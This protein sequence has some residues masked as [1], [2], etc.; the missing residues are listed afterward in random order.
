MIKKFGITIGGLQQKIVNLVLIFALL[1]IGLFVTVSIYMAKD[2]TKI[3]EKSGAEQKDSITKVSQ[4]TM[5]GTLNVSMTQS[6]EMQASIADNLFTAAQG[7]VL[8]LQEYAE[9][10]FTHRDEYTDK[11]VPEPLLENDGIPSVQLQHEAAVDPADDP[12]LG[13]LANMNELLL[14][15][16][17]NSGVVNSTLAATTHGDIIFVDDR[18]GANFNDDGTLQTF[19][20]RERPWY[21]GAI[22]KGGLY[23]TGIELDAFTNIP[24]LV[25]S[26]P[27]YANGELVAVVG[28]DVFLYNISEYVN[29]STK[30]GGFVCIVNQNGEIIFSPKKDG[31]FKAVTSD[32]AADLRKGENAEL[33]AFVTKALTDTTGLETVTV[34]GVEYYLCGAP[35]KTVGWTVI[36]GVA[37]ELSDQPTN[38]MLAA[39]DGI[40]NEA[41]GEY[42]KASSHSQNVILLW[43]AILLTLAFIGALT[44]AGRIVKPIETMTRRIDELSEGDLQFKMEDAYRTK[45]EI[46]L[47]A[48]AFA[49]LSAK[50]VQYIGQI[51][52]ITAEKERIGAEL[53]LATRIQ[54]NMLPN[55]FPAFPQRSDFDI[56][57]S[58]TPAKEVGGDFYDFML[59]DDDHLAVVIADVSGKGVPAAL[60]MMMA[61]ILIDNTTRMEG[62]EASPGEVLTR[63][64]N[65]ICANNEEEM[66][67][68]VWLGI[69]DLKTGKVKATNAGHEYPIIKKADGKFELLKDKHGMVV[70]AMEGLRYKDY[71]FKLEEGGTLFLYTD[72]V[73]EATNA[74]NKLFGTERTIEALNE[75]P[76]ESPEKLLKK[77]KENVDIFVG[78][79][80]QFDDLTMI[81]VKINRQHENEDKNDKDVKS[82]KQ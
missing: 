63:V 48:E 20:V 79:A 15:M 51:T 7:N 60:F 16:Y 25:C 62:P 35:M 71:E 14:S 33:G 1:I 18:A 29:D 54:A 23:Y 13:L 42:N 56:Y 30:Y 67:V 49:E 22:E 47:L 64:N 81:S 19:E 8:T 57:A 76:E 12:D 74:E 44:V 37:K 24:G 46:E 65:T 36:S 27:V 38:A 52:T 21:T 66:F 43:T 28:A 4:E 2:L 6:A 5:Q 32:Q 73:A 9:Y 34:D 26:A 69:L 11:T 17:N 70:G 68:T 41:L 10:L 31:T 45:D 80:P 59:L 61:M 72:G 58:M 55:L 75:I 3:V 40:N 82:D 50:T 77:V 53:E 39:Y 78:E